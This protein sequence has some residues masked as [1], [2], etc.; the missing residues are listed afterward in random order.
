VKGIMTTKINL[1]KTTML[2]LLTVLLFSFEIF[3]AKKKG[4]PPAPPRALAVEMGTPFHDHGILQR[5]MKV[6]VWGWSQP[7]TK[8]S[9][10]FAGQTKSST[11]GQDGKWMVH[12]DPLM[13]SFEPGEMVITETGGKTETL[14]DILVGEVWMCSGQSN[15]Q[16][17]ASQCI[18]G[19]KLIKEMLER[20]EAGKEKRPVIREGKVTN[21]FSSLRPK[22]R[23]TLG[24]WSDSWM[25]FS[26]VAFA[27]SY[28]VWKEV[29]V[30]VGIVNCSFST[31]Q[32]Q[33]WVPREGFAVGKDE[34]TKEIYQRILEGD[35]TTPEHKKAFADYYK[36][37]N[38]W[39]VESA[40]RIKKGLSSPEQP[41][42]PGNLNGNRDATWMCNGK[43]YPMAPYAIRGAIWNQGYANGNEG[44]PYRNNLHSLT[45]G[46]RAL[47]GNPTLPIYY[48]Q[49]YGLGKTWE[50]LD[51]NSIAEMRLGTWLAHNEIPHTAMASQIDITGGVHYYN[52]A[53]PGQRLARHALKNQYG[54]EIIANG[55][56]YKNYKIKGNR[57]ILE[58][59]HA[60]GL[61][62]GRSM[63]VK[64]GFADPI[65]LKDGESQVKLFYIAGKDRVWH[66]AQ[67]KIV[68][69]TIELTAPGCKEPNG[70]AYGTQGV[71]T[72]PS[73]YNKAMLPLTPFIFYEHR[74]VISKQWEVEH[75]KMPSPAKNIDVLPWPEEFLKVAG[76]ERN[77]T[78]YGLRKQH[79]KLWLL[80]PQYVNNCVIQADVPTRFYGKGLANSTVKLVFAGYE[81]SIKLGPTDS[82]WELVVP[83]LKAS[84]EPKTLAVTCLIDGKVAHERILKN[85]IVGDVWYVAAMELKQEKHS[86]VP[87]SGPV[88]REAFESDHPQLRM[89]MSFGKREESKPTRF[90]LNASGNPISRFFSRWSPT[91][92]L[93]KELAQR[94][95]A[96][97]GRP[98]GIVILDT[99]ARPMKGWVSYESLKEHPAWK[100]DVEELTP[101]YVKDPKGLLSNSST[102]ITRWQEY[103]KNVANAHDFETGALPAFPGNSKIG[104]N[105]TKIYCQ[106]I[107]A[108][109]PGNFKAILCLTGKETVS[110]EGAGFGPKFSIMAN[111]WKSAF[112]RGKSTIDP[113]LVYA[114]PTKA[115]APKLTSPTGIKGA[116]SAVEMKAWPTVKY[117]RREDT[118]SYGPGLLDLFDQAVSAVYP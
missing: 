61:C 19:R 77:P 62:V 74:L 24:K 64:G 81:K 34:Y 46:W 59:D 67:V 94:I 80:G 9:V 107:S 75:L 68:G 98:V 58:L 112:D 1:S 50:G 117:D 33:A 44:L 105:A 106:S 89:F 23:G 79:S 53:V 12:L 114:L 96:K 17:N 110:D 91:L 10:S 31:T 30:P 47:W 76:V 88:P 48:H 108:F 113:H 73:I 83:A 66:N 43:L 101:L 109:T 22:A 7:G 115:L 82:E 42:K 90:K 28:D 93:T 104:T 55:P 8:V 37:L 52:K 14:K 13:A 29:Q 49:F 5:D 102:Y 69:K 4:K 71:G 65:P 116:S 6:P 87:K 51:L 56:M 78:T 20:V 25:G 2:L 103:W 32:I 70:V 38:A 16:W 36:E 86:A 97:T 100:S 21:V 54:K 26:A 18:V 99:P 27:F 39:A 72:S 63:T 111:G 40:D 41:K 84:A 3:A 118:F 57:L 85:V 95:H 92:G 35:H 11:A 45:R 60:E 15:M